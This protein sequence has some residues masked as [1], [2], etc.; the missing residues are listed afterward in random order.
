MEDT[1]GLAFYAAA[2]E[3][4][5]AVEA[6][7]I[8]KRKLFVAIDNQARYKDRHGESIKR[9]AAQYYRE[10]KERFNARNRK[11]H[12]ANPHYAVEY[13]LRNAGKIAIQRAAWVKQNPDKARAMWAN[14]RSAEYRA[15]PGWVDRIAIRRV[16]AEATKYRLQVDHIV[17]L[18]HPRVCG[19]HTVAN[20]Q[21]LSAEENRRKGNRYWPDM[22]L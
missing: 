15:V 8:E 9:R 22:P 14:R 5:R 3:Q 7:L 21:L 12:A 1:W 16:Y 4:C 17:P 2:A 6:D 20:L 13:R 19:L 10:N 18:M 11:F